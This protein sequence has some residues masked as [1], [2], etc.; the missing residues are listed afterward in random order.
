MKKLLLSEI[1][2]AASQHVQDQGWWP[3]VVETGQEECQNPP[4]W[5]LLSS[6]KVSF[7]HVAA[8]LPPPVIVSSLQL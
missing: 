1:I 3:Q 2:V 8:S 5:L 4:S 7:E 6:V